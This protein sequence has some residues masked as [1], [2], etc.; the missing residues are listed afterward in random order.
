MEKLKKIVSL[1][2]EDKK[3]TALDENED[4]VQVKNL[5]KTFITMVVL[6]Q[7]RDEFSLCTREWIKLRV[8]ASRV[9]DFIKSLIGN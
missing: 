4:W 6:L 1:L 5:W 9:S 3:Q 8:S 7:I 2:V